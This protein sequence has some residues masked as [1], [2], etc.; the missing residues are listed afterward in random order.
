[1]NKTSFAFWLT[2]TGTLCLVAC[3][4]WM[5]RISTKQ[6]MLLAQL[7]AQG[8]R[9][10]KLSKLEH[11]LIKEVHPQVGEIKEGMDAVVASVKENTENSSL[12]S[13]NK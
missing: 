12:A 4:W 13:K 9:I 2:L 6:N 7:H 5:Y 8:E 3:F 1:M 11:D 10:E